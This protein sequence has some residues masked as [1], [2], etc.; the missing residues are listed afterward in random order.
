MLVVSDASPLIALANLQLLGALRELF[1]EV[2]VPSEVWDELAGA[3]RSVA[4]RELVTAMPEWLRVVQTG[5]A[6]AI[7]GLHVGESAAIQWAIK[8]KADLLLID[9]RDG[10]REAAIR[11]VPVVGTIGLLELMAERELVNLAD[12]FA[13]LQATDFWV[14]PKLLAERL[15]RFR[16]RSN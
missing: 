6:E 9:E 4:V 14:S 8:A 16:R 2:V 10:R 7:P 1:G 5:G 15:E 13:A 12:A 11:G 3:G